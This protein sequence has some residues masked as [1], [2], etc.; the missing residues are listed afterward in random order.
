MSV[1][2]SWAKAVL[3]R[4]NSQSSLEWRAPTRVL[5]SVKDC[6]VLFLAL[7]LDKDCDPDRHLQIQAWVDRAPPHCP[8][9]GAGHGCTKHIL[10]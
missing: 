5:T 10:V 7:T 9:V 2:R 3:H 8:K 1:I 6:R 4:V